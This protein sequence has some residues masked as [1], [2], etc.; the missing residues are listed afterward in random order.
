MQS[1]PN[2]MEPDGYL[3][4]LRRLIM[5][6]TGA[7]MA[8]LLQFRKKILSILVILFAFTFSN[9]IVAA[10]IT[11]RVDNIEASMT[12]GVN[13]GILLTFLGTFTYDPDSVAARKADITVFQ[14]GSPWFLSE[15]L[16]ENWTNTMILTSGPRVGLG[17]VI[18]FFTMRFQD[19]F[20]LEPDGAAPDPIVSLSVR[21]VNSNPTPPQISLGTTTVSGSA[22]VVPEP[23]GLGFFMMA[24]GLMSC[25]LWWRRSTR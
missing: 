19:P 11:Y 20:S 16:P 22:V 3:Y 12:M 13:H 5:K 15:L 21:V 4:K 10:P 18:G 25:W 8:V 2:S 17:P 9:S 1:E 6:I 24:I 7:K 14:G 23:S